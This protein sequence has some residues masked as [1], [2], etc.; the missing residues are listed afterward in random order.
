MAKG[1]YHRKASNRSTSF[2]RTGGRGKKPGSSILV[3]AEGANTESVYFETLR[4]RFAAPTLEIEVEGVGI[5]DPT[6]LVERA[7][8]LRTKRRK[9]AKKDALGLNQLE[10]FDELWIVFDLDVLEPNKLR[11]GLDFAK[12]KKVHVAHTH[13]CFE[14]W[15]LLHLHYTTKSFTCCDEVVKHLGWS[16]YDKSADDTRERITPLIEKSKIQAAV[17]H[18]DRLV[19]HHTSGGTPF[20]GCPSTTVQA[21]IRSIHDSLSPANQFLKL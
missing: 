17:T 1:N 12:K 20:P 2:R 4:N 10:D 3:V 16:G 18:A 11:A 8:N 13:P 7:L 5:N 19:E 9:L 15:L 6:R 21:L 14:F